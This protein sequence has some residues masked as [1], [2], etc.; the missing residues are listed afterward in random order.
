L[1]ASQV[2]EV[3]VTRACL[4]AAISLALTFASGAQAQ[5]DLNAVKRGVQGCPDLAADPS[6]GAL[7]ALL[8]RPLSRSSLDLPIN[9][10]GAVALYVR[11]GS[12]ELQLRNEFA[13]LAR[14]SLGLASYNSL[15]QLLA[16]GAVLTGSQ[17]S[18]R[19]S[20]LAQAADPSTPPATAAALL[21]QAAALRTG[22]F[23]ASIPQLLATRVDRDR[24]ADLRTG[25][26]ATAGGANSVDAFAAGLALTPSG[27]IG[28]APF[29]VDADG[30][31]VLSGYSFAYSSYPFFVG[32]DGIANTADDLPYVTNNPVALAA[33]Y[34]LGAPISGTTQD[35]FDAIDLTTGTPEFSA[36][37]QRTVPSLANPAV[38]K[39]VEVYAIY[40]A[41][42]KVR[43][44]CQALNGTYTRASNTCTDA[45]SHDITSAAI[46]AACPYLAS[47]AGSTSFGIGQ[48]LDGD[49]IQV[50]TTTGSQPSAEI[51]AE[52]LPLLSDPALRPSQAG[53]EP[54]DL[55]DLRLRA[56]L[57]PARPS[58]ANG[59]VVFPP[60]SGGFRRLVDGSTGAPIGSS[61]GSCSVRVNGSN[62]PVG[63]NG[64][65][66]DGDDA[67]ASAGNCLLWSPPDPNGVQHLASTAA[68]AANHSANQTLFHE[69]CTATF[70]E[71]IGDCSLDLLNDG[72]DPYVIPL[73]GGL[74][75]LGSVELNGLE[76][77]R[78]SADP[79]K[80]PIA[81]VS[82]YQVFAIN[83]LGDQTI[84]AQDPG[85]VLDS[86]QQSLLGCGPAFASPCDRQQGVVWGA[87]PAIN[88]SVGSRPFGNIDLMNADASVLTQE[89][90]ARKALHAD[91]LVGVS[92]AGNYLAGI[93]FSR[94]GTLVSVTVPGQRSG[95]GVET[96]SYL[97]L[98]AGDVAGM[99]QAQRASYQHG[100]PNKVQADGWIE[101]MPWAVDPNALATFGAV[102]FQVDP[103]DP[104]NGSG[105][106]FNH[107]GGQIYGE[108][109]GRW[110]TTANVSDPNTPFNQTCT[111]LESLSANLER[112]LMVG[113]ILG[114]D[115]IFD[116]PQ[117]L[118][119]LSVMLD[120]D[121]N[122]DATGDPV[123][124]PDGIFAR[125]AFVFS[126]SEMDFQ[127]VALRNSSYLGEM[128]T[129]S[130]DPSAFFESYSPA[131]CSLSSDCLLKVGVTSDNT[132]I[133][134]AWPISSV[135]NVAPPGTGTMRVN[136]AKLARDHRFDLAHLLALQVVTVEGQAVV[137][138][139]DQRDF[140]LSPANMQ[141]N[142]IRDLDNDGINDLDQDR[143]GV[144]DGADDFTPGPVSDDEVFC[145][146]G[147]PGD[148]LQDGI[149]YRPWRADQAPGTPAF[150]ALF[151]NGL[152]P[153]SP[154]FCHSLNALLGTV[155]TAP[156]GTT[157]FLWH[158]GIATNSLDADGDSI[159]DGIDNCPTVANPGQED[160]DADG[161]GD[162][163]DNCVNV[164]NPRVA[165][166]FL[167]LNPWA[168]LSGGQRDDDHDGYGNVC[169]GDFP[170]T[171]QGGNVSPADTAQFMT[172]I[173]KSRAN[174]NC[175][176][177][178]TTPCAV[179]DLNLG[180]NTDNVTN[181]SPADVA[182]FK[183]LLD[184]PPGPKC[185]LCT[186]ATSGPLPCTAGAQ[187]SCQ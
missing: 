108:Y 58:T 111:A 80:L 178:G 64:V 187:G 19:R 11:A 6:L 15:I 9:P 146:S 140:L 92:A 24:L 115:R 169:D 179:F 124:G 20:L 125:N 55:T 60:V 118:E 165:A 119:E 117:T 168:T 98:T 135:V 74:G 84:P 1:P 49:C 139:K 10:G 151:P 177:G 16:Q 26:M 112:Y 131:S 33:G 42:F 17:E 18:L 70:D 129:P 133:V 61:G 170:G 163:C 40:N 63:P 128:V 97:P 68:V 132:P 126:T 183:Q 39:L 158:G 3:T 29:A 4:A 71:D 180:Q 45:G 157:Q 127:V 31:V 145:G 162:V 78:R 65:A 149:Q 182:R 113:S 46:Q 175:G 7:A 106:V 32:P 147:L 22:T 59:S 99:S 27:T 164:K 121:P 159:P 52:V 181:I 123:S 90:T 54:A 104:I 100:G 44:G 134:L 166:N 142:A 73:L 37:A 67:F 25:L 69:L 107:A 137:M 47:S 120:G 83:P 8:C 167:A 143:D 56:Q 48:N 172:A 82:E 21:A 81:V 12:F 148:L 91:E 102:V 176:T 79:F 77:I 122:N 35:R 101:P 72:N 53:V 85:V 86:K 43:F 89:F 66:G 2:E 185:A 161:V 38:N 34:V 184:H 30:N 103:N 75:V 144:W 14:T 110:M 50:N 62:V 5:I 130:G 174:D 152:P 96:G 87:D 173:G 154:V 36:T 93:N 153:R 136:L 116:P 28:G 186:G 57:L 23:D 41:P 114:Q 150:Q 171:S 51:Q 156:N 76:T 94:N 138:S 105:N 155:G 109:C 88:A 141:S 95:V 160:A 13:N